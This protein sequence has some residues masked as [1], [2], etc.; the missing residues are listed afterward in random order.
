MH[1]TN[2]WCLPAAELSTEERSGSAWSC[3]GAAVSL[4]CALPALPLCIPA[5]SAWAL[6]SLRGRK[7]PSARSLHPSGASIPQDCAS[8]PAAAVSVPRSLWSCSAWP[9]SGR[10]WMSVTARL[11]ATLLVS[12]QL[13][14]K[15]V[16]CLSGAVKARPR[17]E[18]L[19]VGLCPSLTVCSW[20]RRVPSPCPSFPGC[21]AQCL[22]REN[23]MASHSIMVADCWDSP[24][25]SLCLPQNAEELPHISK[26]PSC[27]GT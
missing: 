14:P 25:R 5:C 1:C 26:G 20:T 15:M 17:E 12:L 19:Q 7:V 24:D 16:L 18:Q 23:T 13:W 2:P 21:I 9:G 11:W 4:C 10:C 8:P 22:P 3:W 27:P 6:L